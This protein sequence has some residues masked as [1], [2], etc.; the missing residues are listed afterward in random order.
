MRVASAVVAATA[1]CRRLDWVPLN[2]R[3]TNEGSSLARNDAVIG[4]STN[5]TRIH[6]SHGNITQSYTVHVLRASSWGKKMI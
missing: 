4:I 5:N 6:H 3:G 1:D 2:E